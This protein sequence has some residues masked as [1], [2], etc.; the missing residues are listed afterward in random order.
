MI[1]VSCLGFAFGKWAE[2]FKIMSGETALDDSPLPLLFW[3][4]FAVVGETFRHP[5]YL[6]SSFFFALMMSFSFLIFSFISFLPNPTSTNRSGLPDLQALRVP[7]K[8]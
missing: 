5:V 3:V 8:S 2:I 1:V 4:P 7:V 6:D